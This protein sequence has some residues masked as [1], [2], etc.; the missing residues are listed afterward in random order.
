[1]RLRLLIGLALLTLLLGSAGGSGRES[2]RRGSVRYSVATYAT[3]IFIRD[4]Y[5]RL[6]DSLLYA[7]TYHCFCRSTIHNLPKS[8][9]DGSRLQVKPSMAIIVEPLVVDL[10]SMDGVYARRTYDL[11]RGRRNPRFRCGYFHTL[12]LIANRRY[13]AFSRDTLANKELIGRV[14]AGRFAPADVARMQEHYPHDYICDDYTFL[15]PDL[16]R[17]GPQVLFDL[18]SPAD[19]TATGK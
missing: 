10:R 12:F 4:K 14:F 5:Q 6:F 7:P 19:S 8:L 11:R 16:I 3:E 13:Y 1:M 17:R 18:H 9:G 2:C 15:P